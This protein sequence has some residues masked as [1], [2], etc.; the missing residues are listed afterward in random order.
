MVARGTSNPEAVGSSPTFGDGLTMSL[1][2]ETFWGLVVCI[3]TW[4]V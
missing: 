3:F 4:T 1:L 2:F